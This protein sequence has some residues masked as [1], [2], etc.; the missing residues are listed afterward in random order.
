MN[1][2]E[3]YEDGLASLETVVITGDVGDKKDQVCRTERGD[4]H[5]SENYFIMR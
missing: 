4:Y 3:G 1:G 5:G 2:G